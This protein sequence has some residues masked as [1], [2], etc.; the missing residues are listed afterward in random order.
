LGVRHGGVGLKLKVCVAAG[1]VGG[2]RASGE[3]AA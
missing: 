2:L 1:V 3:R